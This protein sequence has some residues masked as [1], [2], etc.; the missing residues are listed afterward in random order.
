MGRFGVGGK[1]IFALRNRQG[2]F[3]PLVPSTENGAKPRI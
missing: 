3:R 1:R 2:Q